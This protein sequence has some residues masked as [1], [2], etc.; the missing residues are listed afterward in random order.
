M[1]ENT[2]KPKKET[3]RVEKDFI[4]KIAKQLGEHEKRLSNIEAL[5]ELEKEIKGTPIEKNQGM[6]R[7][8]G[9]PDIDIEINFLDQGT[10]TM[11]K[12]RIDGI[13]L[14]GK[15]EDLMKEYGVK[16]IKLIYNR[17]ER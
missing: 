16:S 14:Q 11:E 9:K 5:N 1:S 3:V 10:M 15:I 13:G 7:I 17:E 12:I 2:Q 8:I 4:L 6:M